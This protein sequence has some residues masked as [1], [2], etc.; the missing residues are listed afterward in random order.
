MNK[1]QV[2]SEHTPTPW[3]TGGNGGLIVFASDGYAVAN[4]TV[5]HG[6]QEDGE[7]AANSRYIVRA[8]N[9]HAALV[10]AVEGILEKMNEIPDYPDGC[11]KDRVFAEFEFDALRAALALAKGE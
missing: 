11:Q 4:A 5:F 10:A 7:S 9:S 8:V 6:K 2:N 3:H 1:P